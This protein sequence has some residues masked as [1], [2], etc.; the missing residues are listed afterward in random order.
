[1]PARS[2]AP[3]SCGTEVPPGTRCCSG[4]PSKPSRREADGPPSGRCGGTKNM[5]PAGHGANSRDWEA[6]PRRGAPS[7]RRG[8]PWLAVAG[9]A[10]AVPLSGRCS[11]EFFSG[12]GRLS[13]ALARQGIDCWAYDVQDGPGADLMC[14]RVR[15]SILN[16]VRNRQVASVHFGF[17]CNTFSRARRP[18]GG[19]PP[20]LR[21][22][23]FPWG[24]PDL[25]GKNAEKVLV[26]NSL[27]RFMVKVCRLATKK[28][29]PWSIENPLTSI[30][31]IVPEV[32]SMLF[33]TKA[34]QAR[35]DFCQFG[36]PWRKSTRISGTLEGL[37]EAT[38][39]CTGSLCSRT[40]KPHQQLSGRNPDGVFWTQIAQPDP[41]KLCNLIST[42][43][44]SSITPLPSHART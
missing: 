42:L 31:W 22:N 24:F 8:A 3:I 33:H 6:V 14:R 39:K 29:I 38:R 10:A 9:S 1:M 16:Q 40:G 34:S 44:A 7:V 28:R 19:G 18:G 13:K 15:A 41:I 30:L 12:C 25:V 35:F 11:L 36:T 23:R 5:G 32:R 17:P 27:L 37:G 4:A 21:S 20:P 26:A 43:H 2:C